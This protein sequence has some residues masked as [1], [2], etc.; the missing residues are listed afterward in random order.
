MSMNKK[1][2]KILSLAVVLAVAG[3][4]LSWAQGVVEDKDTIEKRGPGGLDVPTETA[5][6]PSPPAQEKSASEQMNKA[7]KKA[8]K[9]ENKDTEKK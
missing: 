9:S 6:T 3:P 4:S 1:V 5:P 2:F 7:E 8:E